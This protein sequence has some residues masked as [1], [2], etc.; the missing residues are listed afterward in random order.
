MKPPETILWART[1]LV[2]VWKS[3]R[4]ELC[5]EQTSEDQHKTEYL[6]LVY[7]YSSCPRW[8]DFYFEECTRKHAR[9]YGW[10][11]RSAFNKA[12]IGWGR[13]TQSSSCGVF[14]QQLVNTDV[15][16]LYQDRAEKR[17]DVWVSNPSVSIPFFFLFTLFNIYFWCFV[18]NG[19]RLIIWC[20]SFVSYSGDSISGKWWVE[21]PFRLVGGL[22]Y[23]FGL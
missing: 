17:A 19:S 3:V 16:C 13:Q 15:R 4:R 12:E 23:W 18:C 9:H 20:W 8:E 11:G 14:Q 2:T 7:I 22:V 5:V 21:A 10:L 1:E 6:M